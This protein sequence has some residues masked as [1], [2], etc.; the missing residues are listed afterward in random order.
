MNA[1]PCSLACMLVSQYNNPLCAN[2]TTLLNDKHNTIFS[3]Q[4]KR[5]AVAF[6]CFA[7]NW[8]SLCELFAGVVVIAGR[9]DQILVLKREREREGDDMR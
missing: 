5:N 9:G 8:E 6:R 7:E 1:A 3:I 2:F 4:L